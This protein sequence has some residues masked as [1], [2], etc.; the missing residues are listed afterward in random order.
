MACANEFFKD[1]LAIWQLSSDIDRQKF[2]IVVKSR[3]VSFACA[4]VWGYRDSGI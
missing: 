1:L 3:G 2:A 4:A